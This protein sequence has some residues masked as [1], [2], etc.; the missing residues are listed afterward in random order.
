MTTYMIHK[1]NLFVMNKFFQT[2]YIWFMHH[3]QR[4]FQADMG[5]V[6]I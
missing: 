5:E 4:R 6:R 2:G 1:I 3:Q